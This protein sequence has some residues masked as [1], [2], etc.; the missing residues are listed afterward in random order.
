MESSER[1]AGCE[2][3]AAY[4]NVLTHGDGS[5]SFLVFAASVGA[6]SPLVPPVLVTPELSVA[7]RADGIVILRSM[8]GLSGATLGAGLDG[9]AARDGSGHRELPGAADA[10]ARLPE[11]RRQI[12][13]HSPPS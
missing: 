11:V 6:Q 10:L 9:V 1:R 8:F 4:R 12:R 13:R 3:P 2:E 5:A 7:N